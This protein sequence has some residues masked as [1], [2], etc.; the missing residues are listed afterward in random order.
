[1]K[2]KS[3]LNRLGIFFGG[4]FATKISA[5]A[6]DYLL[7]PFVIYHLG[8][9][10]GFVVMLILSFVT[11]YLLIFLYDKTKIDIFGFEKLK[12]LKDKTNKEKTS[13][14]AKLVSMGYV[15][16][17][18]ALSFY[19]PFFATLW[20]RKSTKFDGMTKRDWRIL[21]LSTIIGNLLWA[22]TVFGAL[23]LIKG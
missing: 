3:F 13:L 17:F 9:K 11:N 15:V 20:F 18:I 19:D 4:I 23:K 6:F 10:W 2:N 12:D 14:L 22:P 8:L 1:M 16:T 21:T 7:Y 5:Y